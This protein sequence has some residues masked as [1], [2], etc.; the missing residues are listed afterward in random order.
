MATASSFF[1]IGSIRGKVVRKPMLISGLN[2]LLIGGVAVAVSY[3][4]GYLLS[5]I[6]G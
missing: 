2:T 1:L 5:I 3:C 6:I 4:I